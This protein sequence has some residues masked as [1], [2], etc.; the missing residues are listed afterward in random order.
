MCYHYTAPLWSESIPTSL[1]TLFILRLL[2]LSGEKSHHSPFHLNASSCV[3]SCGKFSERPLTKNK[4]DVSTWLAQSIKVQA[5]F[6]PT[7]TSPPPPFQNTHPTYKPWTGKF[8]CSPSGEQERGA[9]TLN[10]PTISHSRQPS[11]E[12]LKV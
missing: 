1:I 9:H 7:E 4:K 10:L 2:C 11:H 5:E 6:S 8:I 12:V 3:T